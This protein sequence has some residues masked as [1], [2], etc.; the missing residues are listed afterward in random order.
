MATYFFHEETSPTGDDGL[1]TLV[2]YY[3]DDISA[4]VL[5]RSFRLSSMSG[6]KEFLDNERVPLADL[7]ADLKIELTRFLYRRLEQEIRL[8]S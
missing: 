3:Y 7:R 1:S 8:A 4:E 5:T 6:R 2:R